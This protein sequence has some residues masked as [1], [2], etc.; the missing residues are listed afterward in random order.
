MAV[1][2]S[3]ILGAVTT[4]VRR[5][6]P[7]FVS[8]HQLAEEMGMSPQLLH[9]YLKQIG[10]KVHY[11]GD[12]RNAPRFVAASEVVDI[13]NSILAYQRRRPVPGK[14]TDEAASELGLSVNTVRVLVASEK[15]R[16]RRVR[17]RLS[18]S[19]GELARYRKRRRV[20]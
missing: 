13:V 6:L 4:K 20:A 19:D 18:F 1:K 10:A 12:P 11:V 3:D 2:E 8:V 14:T 5:R 15:L 17:R 16:P 9:Y 7:K